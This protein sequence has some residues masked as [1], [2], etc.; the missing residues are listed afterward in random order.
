MFWQSPAL[1]L[2]FRLVLVIEGK[3][4]FEIAMLNNSLE[5][6]KKRLLKS[7]HKQEEYFEFCFEMLR[8]DTL[9]FK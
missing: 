6:S 8:R 3:R 4:T 7:Y 1:C 2:K 5:S 9:K